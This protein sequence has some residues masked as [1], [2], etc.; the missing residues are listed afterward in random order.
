MKSMESIPEPSSPMERS[1]LAAAARAL[2]RAIGAAGVKT[3]LLTL[4]V[5]GLAAALFPIRT[6]G[7]LAVAVLGFAGALEVARREA[8]THIEQS[9]QFTHPPTF[10]AALD[11]HPRWR[12]QVLD[13]FEYGGLRFNTIG[14]EEM[15]IPLAVSEP[16]CPACQ[17]QVHFI[18][19]LRFP[20]RP[21]TRAV[22]PW[23]GWR[24]HGATPAYRDLMVAAYQIGCALK[25]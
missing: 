22:C 4:G 15:P 16:L 23:C 20:V 3:G 9:R 17:R 10:F 21:E 12:A 25:D 8:E 5:F 24:S 18:T 13:Q 7:A 6:A 2:E 19:V 1:V 14:F 11:C